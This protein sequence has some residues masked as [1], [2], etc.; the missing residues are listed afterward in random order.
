MNFILVFYSHLDIKS[1][2]CSFYGTK[3]TKTVF[4]VGPQP[5]VFLQTSED[6]KV[7]YKLNS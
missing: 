6:I 1:L 7:N 5:I 2:I 3:K 4:W